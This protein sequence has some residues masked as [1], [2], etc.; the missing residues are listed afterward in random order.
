MKTYQTTLFLSPKRIDAMIN[1]CNILFV[2][3]T[4]TDAQNIDD[5]RIC[6]ENILIEDPS[7]VRGL[8]NLGA[9]YQSLTGHDDE[10][11]NVCINDDS[12]DSKNNNNHNDNENNNDKYK[13]KNDDTKNVNN[14]NDNDDYDKK[15]QKNN[16]NKL[17]AID[18]YNRA[19][20]IDVENVMAKHALQTLSGKSENSMNLEY[21]T[22]LFDSYSFHF[23]QSL[24]LLDYK[25]HLLVAQAVGKYLFY[26]IPDTE[27][28]EILDTDIFG[29]DL[30]AG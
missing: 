13:I 5:I 6:Y 20:L 2:I 22:Q 19:L 28:F 9:F 16:D 23:D 14:N 11:K 26:E 1:Y 10:N 12:C 25:S 29:L 30:G 21:I 27:I 24:K 17:K 18:L 8:V 15:I 3:H 7:S 4:N